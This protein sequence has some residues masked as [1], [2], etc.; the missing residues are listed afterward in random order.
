MG[1]ICPFN[2]KFRVRK[3]TNHMV[4]VSAGTR[5]NKRTWLFRKETVN[6]RYK[7]NDTEERR[8]EAGVYLI[9]D[10]L[11]TMNSATRTTINKAPPMKKPIHQGGPKGNRYRG[12]PRVQAVRAGR[13]QCCTVD[14]PAKAGWS[15]RSQSAP[16]A[17]KPVT[18]SATR[19]LTPIWIEKIAPN[20]WTSNIRTGRLTNLGKVYAKRIAADRMLTLSGLGKFLDS[21][22]GA[23]YPA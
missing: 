21:S 12:T 5:R 1:R 17:V 23:L 10:G 22:T 18:K 11:I 6:I 16:V 7:A 9:S 15:R 4:T 8:I 14:L 20:N 2:R 13:I 3:Q 19:V